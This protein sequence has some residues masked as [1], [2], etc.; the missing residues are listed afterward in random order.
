[1]AWLQIIEKSRIGTA[2][3]RNN[4]RVVV[5]VFFRF[6]D[7]VGNDFGVLRAGLDTLPAADAALMQNFNAVFANRY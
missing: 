4:G 2:H 5:Q 1:L 6:A 7:R 3:D